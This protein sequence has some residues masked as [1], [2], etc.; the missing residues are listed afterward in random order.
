M[1]RGDGLRRQ[2]EMEALFP[3]TVTHSLTLLAKAGTKNSWVCVLVPGQ[4]LS[5][6][7]P[8]HIKLNTETGES[9]WHTN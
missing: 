5:V 8:N 3:A 7:F 9:F 4:L 6:P 2:I 1:R